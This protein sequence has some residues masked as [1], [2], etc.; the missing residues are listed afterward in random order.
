MDATS[1]KIQTMRD[2]LLTRGV[3][4]AAILGFFTLIGSLS[5]IWFSGWHPLMYLHIAIYLIVLGLAINGRFLSFSIRAGIISGVTLV[6]GIGLLVGGGFASFGLLSL[7]CF[8]IISTILISARAG[9]I[10]CLIC[11]GIIGGIGAGV[12]FGILHFQYNRFL[13]LNSGVLWIT[14]IFAMALSAGIIVVILGALNNQVE[15][16]A[17]TLEKQNQEIKEKNRLL[18]KDLAERDRMEEE[19]IILEGKLRLAQKLETIGQLAGG[20]AHDLNNTLGSII[21]YPELLLMDLPLDSPM[22]DPLEKIR[23]TGIKA[24]TIVNDMLTLARSGIVRTEV[25]DLNS[26]I[27]EYFKSPEFAQLI[28][29][30]QAVQ[31]E[32]Q[33]D[34]DA[35][36]IRGSFFHLSKVL[37][38]LVS[39][40]AEAM[41]DGG[42]IVISSERLYV[43]AGSGLDSQLTLGEYAVLSVSDTG[44][45]IPE[46][47]LEKI[48]EPFYTKKT[49]GRSG[50]GLGMSVVWSSVKDHNGH[51]TVDSIEGKG[52]T[53][54]VFIPLTK[55]EA[56]VSKYPFSQKDLMGQ[57]ESILVV[58]DVGEQRE[59]AVKL[60]GR[61]GYSVHAVGSGEEAI[62]YLQRASADLLILDMVMD[63]GMDGLDTYR[64]ILESHPKQKAIIASGYSETSR[65]K[66]ALSL[67]AGAY[68]KKPFFYNQLGYAVRTELDRLFRNGSNAPGPWN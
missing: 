68:L 53:F 52:T 6:L 49:M 36:N 13:E 4:A 29:F 38:N 64:K 21:G 9:F 66:D 1:E 65:V 55:E 58:D 42:R 32:I 63:P 43:G 31:I 16:L 17:C 50:T 12:H 3:K 2:Q 23:K 11:I 60:L 51:I 37:M 33:A 67:G 27:S 24:A 47:D 56:T 5:R 14:A 18:E 62:A 10:S 20:V 40:A 44:I 61:M 34:K 30:H 26:V 46:G 48:F 15:R 39:N 28:S 8:C 59:I 25:F 35:L 41:P 19:R 57:G 7:F 22:R 45:G 54:K